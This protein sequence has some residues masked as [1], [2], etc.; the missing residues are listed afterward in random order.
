[1]VK[2]I[3]LAGMAGS[4]KSTVARMIAKKYGFEFF[5]GGDAL[6]QFAKEQ[7]YSVSGDDWW[8][9]AQGIKFLNHRLTDKS[10]D[11]KIDSILIKRAKKGGVVIT[12]WALPWLFKGGFKIWLSAGYEARAKRIVGRDKIKYEQALEAVKKRDE[13]NISLYKQLYNYDL[14]SD[15]APF[16]LVINT[17]LF[18]ADKVFQIADKAISL[19]KW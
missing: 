11:K 4:G 8:E 3:I 14:S 7:G 16:D 10:F 9:T 5:C 17:D 15:L 13:T 12:S 1:M 19:L 18:L 2:T 6:K